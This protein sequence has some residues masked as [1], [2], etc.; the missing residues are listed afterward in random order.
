MH[1]AHRFKG[2]VRW[3]SADTELKVDIGFREIGEILNI[4]DAEKMKQS[5]LIQLLNI[6]FDKMMRPVL[7]I[8]DNVEAIEHIQLFL[9][10]M[11]RN[12]RFLITTR[13][14]GFKS[15]YDVKDILLGPFNRVEAEAFLKKSFNRTIHGEEQKE[16]ILENELKHEVVFPYKLKHL[17]VYLYENR[18][19]IKNNQ[20]QL[21]PT[22]DIEFE[23]QLIQSIKEQSEMAYEV[24]KYCSYLD[25]DRILWQIIQYLIEKKETETREL[26]KLLVKQS[27]LKKTRK[28]FYVIHRLTQEMVR[29][30]IS[31]DEQYCVQIEIGQILSEKLPA[32]TFEHEKER[33][34]VYK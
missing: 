16:E 3:I 20:L 25:A 32:F 17:A 12:T 2:I 23:K 18:Q 4:R 26:I 13:D 21:Y 27:L 6:E 15:K 10:N 11:Y 31:H 5:T 19:Q 8:L 30:N 22:N 33:E 9:V 14:E 29:R 34:M 24:L 7:I 28:G 1:Y